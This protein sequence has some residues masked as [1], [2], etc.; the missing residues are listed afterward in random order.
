M[1]NFYIENYTLAQ[2]PNPFLKFKPFI[3]ANSQLEGCTAINYNTGP[4]QAVR[5]VIVGVAL[6]SMFLSVSVALTI[7]YNAKLRIH[8]SKLIGYMCINEALSCFHAL[9]WTIG[10]TD[11]ICYFGLHYLFSY[12]I[13]L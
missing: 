13:G 7:F 6:L 3:L 1:E 11:F 5:G 10:P 4:P 12:T 8:P 9:I 2:T